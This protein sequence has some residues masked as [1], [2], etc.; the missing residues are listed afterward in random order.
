MLFILAKTDVVRSLKAVLTAVFVLVAAALAAVFLHF[1]LL[2]LVVP[3][4]LVCLFGIFKSELST[5]VK[6][7]L[8]L[9]IMSAAL[10]FFGDF[11]YIDDALDGEWARFNTVL[12]IYLQLWVFLSISAAFAVHY[13]CAR[14]GKKTKVIW[15]ALLVVLVIMSIIHPLAATTSILS[16]R[17]EYWGIE[18]G[19]LDGMAYI[20]TVDEGDYHALQWINEEI[21]G[22]PMVLEAAG[23][24]GSYSSRV[25]AFTGMHTVI[26]WVTWERM[27]RLDWGGIDERNNDVN[28]MYNTLDNDEALALLRKYGVS[29]VYIGRLER[30][31]YEAGGLQKF[32]AQ[33]EYYTPIYDREG[34][35]IF[36]VRGD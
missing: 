31:T 5:V 20:E 12:K 21:E 19:T 26:G 36:Q 22:T 18:R 16:G 10:A 32:A 4:T 35:T 29:Y 3:V 13:V 1:Q 14:L 23:S 17:N 2:G 11:L 27:W 9:V 33:P 25:S 28:T 6:F 7:V 15:V 30:E 24:P 8:L 34:V